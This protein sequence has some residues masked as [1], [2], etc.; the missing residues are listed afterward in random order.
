[1]AK[2]QAGAACRNHVGSIITRGIKAG[3]FVLRGLA[4]DKEALK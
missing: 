2:T 3:G 4:A 1:M